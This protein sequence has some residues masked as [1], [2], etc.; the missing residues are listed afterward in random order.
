MIIKYIILIFISI[1]AIFFGIRNDI[2]LKEYCRLSDE[3]YK[4]I[5]DSYK[6][7]LKPIYDFNDIPDYET[8]MFKEIFRFKWELNKLKK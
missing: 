4:H 6:I 8:M 7:G 5:V 3:I 1:I 2:I